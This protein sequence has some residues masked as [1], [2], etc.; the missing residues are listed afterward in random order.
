MK[1]TAILIGAALVVADIVNAEPR[2]ARDTADVR[3]KGSYSVG[4][5]APLK[6][7]VTD[8]VE[9][10]AHPLVFFVAPHVTARF[11]LLKSSVR[12]TAETGL[13]VPTFAM[14]LT[15]GYLFP[16]WAQSSNQIPFML[17][18]RIGFLASGGAPTKH[19]WTGVVDFAARVP[20]G[21]VNAGPLDSFL[22]PLDLLF[23]APL[24]GFVSRVGGA[25]D[26]ALGERLRT[27]LEANIHLTGS[28]NTFAVQTQNVGPLAAL[29]PWIFSAHAAL[30][31]A[32]GT[33]SRLS[34]GVWWGNADTGASVVVPTQNGF[35]DRVRVRS[36]NILPTID[37]IWSG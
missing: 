25:Y 34:L 15:K 23:A 7:A 21:T 5:F 31:I 33:S 37:F 27:R 26:I 11:A 20:F 9:L 30:D 4:V 24:T 29:S 14:R 3:T 19:V 2:V 6:I 16:T 12:L 17:V 18:P 35:S 13:S 8:S 28:G 10:Q 36:N 1:S 22:A 32:V